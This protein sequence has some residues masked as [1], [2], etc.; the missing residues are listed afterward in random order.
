MTTRN[1]L[2]TIAGIILLMAAMTSS[3]LF[4]GDIDRTQRPKP[5]PTPQIQ[6]PEIQKGALKNGLP[7]WLV[8]MHKLPTVAFNLVLQAGSDQDPAG[9]AGVA[10]M[11]ANVIDGGT[12]TRDAMGIAAALEE[13]GA[14][15]NANAM[16]DGSFLTLNT[17]TKNL[18]KALAIYAD[19]LTNATFP[20]KEFERL[21][22]QRIV[23]LK[24][25][26][27]AA[28]N[29]ATNAFGYILYGEGH[30]YS[31]PTGGT[32]TSLPNVKREDLVAFYEKFYRPNN[33]TL[34]VVGDVTMDQILPKLEAA[35]ADWKPGESNLVPLP[36]TKPVEKMRVYLVDKPGAPQS[37]IRIGCPALSRS[38]PD[39]FAVNLMNRMLGGQFTSRIN[40]NLREKHGYTYGARSVFTFLKGPGPF[41]ASSGVVTEKTDSSVIEF[42]HELNLMHDK[43]MTA[44]ELDYSRKGT[45]GGFLLNFETPSQIAGALQNILLYKL[46]EDYYR[47]YLVNIDNVTL[48]DVNNVAKK[49]LDTHG[50]DILVCGDLAT[51]KAG[52][53]KLN[54]GEIIIC[55]VN[56]KPVK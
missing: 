46:P 7:V 55:D 35:L 54:L 20:A 4:G 12:K 52:I 50:M 34:I 14:N 27:D 10:S 1:S 26:K 22:K 51:I 25:A 19:V 31:V 45:Q 47:N 37:E 28:A 32:E 5:M 6:L 3:T 41:I 33:G 43:G 40:L 38:T 13:I 44:D 48:D 16:Q 24:A 2:F 53:E 17:L 15:V 8:E 49:Y 29:I 42:L 30:P 9:L 56:G 23:A 36:E 18:D 21:R 39:F 11:T